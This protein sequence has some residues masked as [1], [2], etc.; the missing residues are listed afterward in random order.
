MVV[1]TGSGKYIKRVVI[2]DDE[3][4]AREALKL[5]LKKIKTVDII[6]ECANGYETIAAVEKQKPDLL[7]LDIQMPVLSGFDVLEILGDQAPPTIFI[8][9]YDEYAIKAFEAHALDYLLKP[10]HPARLMKALQ[11]A[12][13]FFKTSAETLVQLNVPLKRILI[14]SGSDIR[15]IPTTEISHIRAQDDFVEIH[16]Q[17][18][19]YLKYERISRLEQLLDNRQFV[20][21]H[22]SYILNIRFLKKIEPYSRDGKMALLTNGLA[23]PVSK[24][25]YKRLL[26]EI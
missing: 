21:V 15:V 8:T 25:G 19:S 7:L 11:H 6:A 2:A 14:R 12:E 17:K 10:V 9:A 18:Q 13:L 4:L 20:R 22:R 1:N 24:S 26:K 23:V 16:S 5:A 3:P